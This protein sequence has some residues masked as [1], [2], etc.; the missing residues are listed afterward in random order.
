MFKQ[1]LL[2]ALVLIPL[3]VVGVLYLPQLF[4]SL[5]VAAVML[6]G[7]WEWTRLIPLNGRSQRSA[8][9][10]LIGLLLLLLGRFVA[11]P[12]WVAVML[13]AGVAWW[14][15]VLA[16][17]RSPKWASDIPLVKILAA[18]PALLPAWG[19]LAVLHGQTVQG[20]QLVLF[21]LVLIWTAD[22]GAYFVGKTLGRHKL[23]PAISP[24]KTWEGVAGG[25]LASAGLAAVAAWW[26]DVPDAQ[27]T[28]FVLLAV[29]SAGCSVIGDLFISLLKRQQG[30]KD[31]GHLIPGH[32][33][34]LDRIDSLLAAAPVFL[35]GYGVMG[36]DA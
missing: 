14:L 18:L 25:L 32:G 9:L 19:A 20:P 3:V 1:R 28:G 4:F 22:S 17:F 26:L 29:V 33:G 2:A 36:F 31:S 21:L 34:I 13:G 10:L 27:K 8:F 16:W 11:D 7:A 6:L 24:G 15:G 30:L 35:F 5:A 12:G 23:A